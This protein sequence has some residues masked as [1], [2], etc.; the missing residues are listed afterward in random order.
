MTERQVVMFNPFTGQPRDPRDIAS[1]P[2]GQLIWDGETPLQATRTPDDFDKWADDWG[3]MSEQHRYV[4]REAWQAARAA[5]AH[6]NKREVTVPHPMLSPTHACKDCGAYWR[7]CDDFTF[8][9]RS[10]KACEACDNTP[11]GGQ[12]IALA[13]L[14]KAA[15]AAPAQPQWQRIPERDKRIGRG[16]DFAGDAWI[17]PASGC[18][19]YTVVGQQPSAPLCA[20]PA[21]PAVWAT[22]EEFA[23]AFNKATG[24]AAQPADERV[25]LVRYVD[26]LGGWRQ[27][28]VD[29]PDRASKAVEYVWATIE[30]I[31]P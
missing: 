22:R 27:S 8:N 13:D 30:R 6:D 4:A 29:V 20:A 15:R 31:A 26:K 5:S 12:L 2:Y 10:P 9:L 14:A 18:V 21:H 24:K 11:V 3:A 28:A 19:Q 25:L 1:D 17:D 23:A 7:Q 16:D